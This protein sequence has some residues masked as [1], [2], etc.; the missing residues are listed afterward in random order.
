MIKSMRPALMLLRVALQQIAMLA[1]VLASLA[2]GAYTL[3]AALGHVPWLDLALSFGGVDYPQAGIW[4]Q[5]GATALLVVL[6]VYL[7]ANGRILALE[8]SHRRFHMGM[9]DV[10]R[11]YAAAHGPTA[12]ACSR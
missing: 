8:N 10:A 3:A 5:S 12:T 2:L 1:I 6:M 7:P 11:A 9:R 4:V